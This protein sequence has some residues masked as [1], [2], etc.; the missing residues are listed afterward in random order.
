MPT[1]S[2]SWVGEALALALKEIRSE[3]RSKHAL[4]TMALFAVATLVVVSFSIPPLN[5]DDPL[6]RQLSPRILA[7]LLWIVLFFS[8]MSGLSRVFV[9]EEDA[10]TVTALRLSARASVV[11]AGKLL[12]NAGLMAAVSIVILPLFVLLFAPR[13]AR[14]DQ[15]I[16]LVLFGALGLSGAST[17]LA[18]I[19]AKTGTR[20]S[21]FVVLALPILLPL[22]VMAMS[23]TA[24][25]LLGGREAEEA[26]R[27]VAGLAAFTTATVTASA[28]LF[29][30]VWEE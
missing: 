11:F 10:R 7:A 25:A 15:M 16:A 5:L 26:W 2:S 28:M 18:A 14:W 23:G 27:S 12:F 9:K 8:A 20:G 29:P 13:I 21:L 19:V 4:A 6:M 30:F 22:L 1:S 24:A 17:L 3:L